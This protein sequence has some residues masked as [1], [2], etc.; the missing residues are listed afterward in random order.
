MLHPWL[1]TKLVG[2]VLMTS[3]HHFM[4]VNQRKF[5]E[6]RNVRTERFWRMVNE[7]PF[8]LAIVMVISVTTEFGG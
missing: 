6:D 2:V 8:L 3:W 5:A 7:V 1:A 4:A